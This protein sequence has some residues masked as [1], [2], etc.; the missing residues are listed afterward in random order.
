[1]PHPHIALVGN[2]APDRQE[3]MQ[4]FAQMLTDAFD[5]SGHAYSLLA[6]TARLSRISKSYRHSGLPKWLGYADKYLLFP[7]SLRKTLSHLRNEGP[8]VA[9]ICD[10]SNAMYATSAAAVGV[11]HVVT[12]HDLLAVRGALGEDTD[13]PASPSGEKLQKWILRSL[14]AAQHVACDSTYT[15]NDLQ[16]LLPGRAPARSSV[17][18]ICL[19]HPYRRLAPAETSRRL[20]AMGFSQNADFILHVGS[21]LNRK[22]KP[23]VLHAAAKA[24]SAFT[25]EIVFAGPALTNE[26]RRL[27]EELGL[28]SRVREVLRPDNDGL[29]TL[30]N[31]ARGLIFPS[32]WEGFGWP[33]IEAQACGC[34]VICGNQSSLPEVAGDAALLCGPDDYPALGDALASLAK[35][36]RREAL[37]AA[38][39]LNLDRFT[40]ARTTDLYFNLYRQLAGSKLR[41]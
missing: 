23:A 26:L 2:F 14:D 37:R 15:Q 35:P 27:A 7:R 3:S 12:C 41:S 4:R 20:A 22:N 33:I 6:P 21:N 13:C 29:E 16:R 25:G 9:H 11:P 38:G 40:P 18:P 17:V 31:A 19:N 30:Y 24:G 1:M 36:G 28:A 8:V 10:H 32:R 5:R 34:P 39:L